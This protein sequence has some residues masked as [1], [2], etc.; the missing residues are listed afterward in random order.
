[1]E[2]VSFLTEQTLSIDCHFRPS[3]CTTNTVLFEVGYILLQVMASPIVGYATRGFSR[4]SCVGIL[5]GVGFR[6]TRVAGIWITIGI[7]TALLCT[8]GMTTSLQTRGAV[9]S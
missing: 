6:V 7:S 5:T 9:T 1:M 3:F 4:I 2:R 8:S